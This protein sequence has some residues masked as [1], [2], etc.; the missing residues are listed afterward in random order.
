MHGFELGLNYHRPFGPWSMELVGLVTRSVLEKRRAGGNTRDGAAPE[1]SNLTQSQRQARGESI[2]RASFA[3]DLTPAHRFEFGGE[4]A[5]NSQQQALS[6]W[7]AAAG[8]NPE[9]QSPR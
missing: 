1:T 9:R 8:A 2:V 4:G 5:F 3:R 7:R 6:R